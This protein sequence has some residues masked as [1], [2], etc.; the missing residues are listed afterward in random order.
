MT[1]YV[2]VVVDG[3]DV[4]IDRCLLNFRK[5][6]EWMMEA[7]IDNRGWKVGVNFANDLS[8][9]ES[10]RIT[11]AV[12]TVIGDVDNCLQMMYVMVVLLPNNMTT[13]LEFVEASEME[14]KV[15]GLPFS[16]PNE[17]ANW[18]EERMKRGN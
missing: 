14:Y 5:R 8:K 4:K 11:K 17:L 13:M 16:K 2:K 3:V 9:D 10:L 12:V 1:E 6:L 18:I 15:D 7:I